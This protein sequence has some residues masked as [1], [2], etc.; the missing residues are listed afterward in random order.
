MVHYAS[1]LTRPAAGAHSSGITY[2]ADFRADPEPSSVAYLVSEGFQCY[3]ENL[4]TLSAP[5][6]DEVRAAVA[7]IR[8]NV[9]GISSKTQNFASAQLGARIVKESAPAVTVVLGGPHVSMAGG[10]VFRCPDIDIAVRGEGEETI[11]ELLNAISSGGTPEGV[12][13]TLFRHGTSVIENPPRNLLMD[14]DALQIG[15]AHV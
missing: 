7:E 2:N 13:G 14:L 10:Q 4:R 15:R 3:L 1:I 5:V 11:V 8:P 12:K 6:W 9:V